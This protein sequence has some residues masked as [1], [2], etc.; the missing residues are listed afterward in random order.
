MKTTKQNI[1]FS[2][3]AAPETAREQPTTTERLPRLDLDLELRA[4]I[5]PLCRLQYGEI[6]QD[7]ISGHRV[8]VLDATK[9]A[10]VAKIMH[11]DRARLVLNDPPYNVQVGN[12]NTANLSKIDL[13]AYLKFSRAWIENSVAVLDDDA[14]FYV[15]L[16]ADV[17]DNFQP[18][19][20]FMI[21][22]RE[23]SELRPRNFITMRNQR[24]YGTQKNWMWV[25]QE[26][27]YYVHGN[28]IFNIEAEY[29]DIPKILRGYYK[30]V[31]GRVTENLERSKSENIRAGNVW[32]DIQQVFYRM[33][34]NVSGCYAQKPLKAI[35]RILQASTNLNELVVDF[36]AHSG[37]TLIAGER[38]GRR[39]YTFD[40][41][42]IFAEITIRRLEHFRAMGKTGWQWENP[43]PEIEK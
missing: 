8:G 17:S 16:G 27:L 10:D 28:P 39:V 31:N 11:G 26:L 9:R 2:L 42:P 7:P 13:D 34:E 38:L 20:D 6:W 40:L 41:D 18:L 15:W 19:P 25:R 37:T 12:A 14:H 30:K 36:F 21:L 43:F 1:L 23:F 5:L 33:Q 4:K 29:T 32:V 24:G 22:M 35:E 3:P